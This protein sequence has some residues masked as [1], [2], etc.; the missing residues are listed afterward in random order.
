[1]QEQSTSV[2]TGFCT[3]SAI[4]L[5]TEIYFYC[6]SRLRSAVSRASDFRASGSGFDT[7]SGRVK[8]FLC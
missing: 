3:L 8:F 5:H 7:W 1:M 6:L 2:K 4:V